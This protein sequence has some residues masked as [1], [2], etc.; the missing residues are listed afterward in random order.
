VC[1]ISNELY[2]VTDLQRIFSYSK[3]SV[4]KLFKLQGFP[5][6]K[7]KRRYYVRPADL[8]RWIERRMN[9]SMV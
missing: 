9:V 7:I 6:I 8:D 4:Y 1:K 2:T 5:Y 3:S